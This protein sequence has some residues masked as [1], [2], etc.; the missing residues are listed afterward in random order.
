MP[1]LRRALRLATALVAATPL[2]AQPRGAAPAP[3]AAAPPAA[4]PRAEPPRE[5]PPVVTEHVMTLKGAPFR[6]TATTGMLPI[7]NEQTGEVEGRMFYV[8]YTRPGQD[9]ATRPLTFVFNGG[10]GSSTVWLHM[11]AYGPKRIRRQPDGAAGPPPYAFEDNPH[12]LLDQTDLVFLD[13]VGTGYSRATRPE[14]GARF[15]GLDEDV[16]AVGE[17]IR[18]WLTRQERWRSPLFVSGE[19]YGTTR[20]AHLSGH[21]IDRGIPLN[22]VILL[23]A[24]L[25]FEQS[26]TAKSND[27]AFV[28]FFPSYAATGWYHRKGGTPLAQHLATAEAFA[29]GPYAA[30]LLAGATLPEAERRAIA[31][32]AARLTFTT[33]ALW[34]EHD[35][36]V[37]LARFSGALLRDQHRMAGRLDSRFSGWSTD[38]GAGGTTFDPSEANIRHSYTPVL[39]DYVRRVLGYRNDDVYYI[40]GGGIGPW[41][42]PVENEYA[43]VTPALERAFAKNPAMRLYIAYGYYDMATPYFAARRTVRALNVAPEV[44]A[45]IREQYFEAGHMMYIDEPSI[46][47]MREG[48]GRFM[49][50]ALAAK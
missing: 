27:A 42:Y 20:A 13:P 8:A 24:V 46:R 7:R 12:T 3:A 41:R 36:R 22:G 35:L 33:P 15:F 30:A 17:F 34:L 29:G 32:Q 43:D 23:S 48:I 18:L 5:E 31:E 40:L 45:T 47:A 10:P 49:S 14:L 1:V 21:L 6:Y 2:L 11:G 26:R 4:A 44:R 38:P 37:P 19:S 25:Q 9:A 50:E 28:N 16:R 39:N